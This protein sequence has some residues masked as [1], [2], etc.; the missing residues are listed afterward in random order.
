[1]TCFRMLCFLMLGNCLAAFKTCL[2]SCSID[3]WLPDMAPI[4]PGSYCSVLPCLHTLL[5]RVWH[6]TAAAGAGEITRLDDG[7]RK[8]LE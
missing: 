3:N 4:C 5:V 6:A 7:Y 1:L 8:V 2:Y